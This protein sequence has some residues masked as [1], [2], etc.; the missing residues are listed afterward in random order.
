MAKIPL[1]HQQLAAPS[2]YRAPVDNSAMQVGN[3]IIQDTSQLASMVNAA[4][5][6]FQRDIQSVLGAAGGAI[7]GYV[8]NKSIQ[9][10]ATAAQAKASS[11]ITAH[12]NAAMASVDTYQKLKDI[13]NEGM[14]SPQ[15]NYNITDNFQHAFQEIKKG[16]I[17]KYYTDTPDPIGAAKFGELMDSTYESQSKDAIN[18]NE[19]RIPVYSQGKVASTAQDLTN[20]VA[21]DPTVLGEAVKQFTTPGMEVTKSL[22]WNPAEAA[23]NS[24]ALINNMAQQGIA[25]AMRIDRDDTISKLSQTKPDADVVDLLQFE[26]NKLHAANALLDSADYSSALT[27]EEKTQH[28]KAIQGLIESNLTDQQQALNHKTDSKIAEATGLGYRGQEALYNGN[29]TSA[30]Q[31]IQAL[32]KQ[33][34]AVEQTGNKDANTTKLLNGYTHAITGI[35][36]VGKEIATAKNQEQQQGFE[37]AKA[38]TAEQLESPQTSEAMEG[39]ETAY[40]ALPRPENVTGSPKQYKIFTE[41]EQAAKHNLEV[42]GF[43]TGPKAAHSAAMYMGAIQNLRNVADEKVKGGSNSFMQKMPF[44]QQAQPVVDKLQTALDK[45][46]ASMNSTSVAPDS[47]HNK[48]NPGRLGRFRADINKEWTLALD[49]QVNAKAKSPQYQAAYKANPAKFIND[50]ASDPRMIDGFIQDYKSRYGFTVPGQSNIVKAPGASGVHVPKKPVK[51]KSAVGLVV[52]PEAVPVKGGELKQLISAE[53]T[54]DG[55]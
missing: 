7:A 26:N 32:M 20:K 33:R 13:T 52:P 41:A 46:Q 22:A 11:L 49:T 3:S 21:A 30:A 5:G 43:G 36:R 25:T 1:Y 29:N 35:Q 54:D 47:I 9:A 45:A 4:Q 23:K 37:Q 15:E 14:K 31:Q 24:K 42:G 53:G 2:T 51:A 39:W 27:S 10:R 55:E 28:K 6:S 12:G 8:V 16:Y 18:A 19:A 17:Q 38:D 48:L 50:V 40:K 34:Q 44:M